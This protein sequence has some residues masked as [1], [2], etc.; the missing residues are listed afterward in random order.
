[1]RK[2]DRRGASIAKLREG[3]EM[4]EMA[5]VIA[6]CCGD[7]VTSQVTTDHLSALLPYI[8]TSWQR[9]QM[10]PRASIQKQR[11]GLPNFASQ[12]NEQVCRSYVRGAPP[13]PGMEQLVFQSG[14]P[15]IES[16]HPHLVNRPIVSCS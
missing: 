2:N 15:L 9:M 3:V 12:A 14:G 5:S 10:A 6:G 16:V 7:K 11:A 4:A 13:C 8:G 1:M